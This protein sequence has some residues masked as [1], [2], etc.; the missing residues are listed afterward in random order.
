MI[1]TVLEHEKIYIGKTRDI[2]KK[3]ISNK[4]VE[5][6][7]IIDIN[8]KGIFK[9][10]NRFI[11]PQQWVGVI[12]LPGLSLEILPKV[13]E[14]YA[15]DEI[16]ETLLYMF[17]VAYNI[18]TKKNVNSKVDFS[19]NGLVEI[20]ISNFLEKV[21]YYIKENLV[22]SYRKVIKN[23]S[24]IKGSIVFQTCLKH[25]ESNEICL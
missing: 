24:T 21:E 14:S 12:S 18:P 5:A 25:Y 23:I 13:T 16:K 22:S 17:K 6:I 20:L 1:L 9:W 11:I 10:G 4:D 15:V 19:K 2:A 7:R 3:Q 8:N